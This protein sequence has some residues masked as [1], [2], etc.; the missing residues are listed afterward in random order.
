M[1]NSLELRVPLLDLPLVEWVWQQP[2]KLKYRSDS[3]KWGLA[4]ATR[5]LIPETILKRKKQGF[6]LP[7]SLWM[8][9]ILKPFMEDCFSQKTLKDCPWL[10][11]APTQ[12]LWQNF[13]QG[14][15][16]RGWSRIWSLAMLITFCQRK[17]QA[18][19][20]KKR[21]CFLLVLL[22]AVLE[23]GDICGFLL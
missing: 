22:H 4:Q 21:Y 14:S 15:D 13:I 23:Q 1:A 3:T 11:V 16:S 9:G 7:F 17:K 5:D 19:P 8:Q 20:S 10:E 6:T 12:R 2:T 18:A